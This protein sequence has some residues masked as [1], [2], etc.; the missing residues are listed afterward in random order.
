[1]N[2]Y[3]LWQPQIE[4]IEGRQVINTR[5][6]IR[7]DQINALK[8]VLI[9]RISKPSS[10]QSNTQKPSD[11]TLLNILLTNDR[12][13]VKHINFREISHMF[14]SANQYLFKKYLCI[15]SNEFHSS[16]ICLEL[17]LFLDQRKLGSNDSFIVAFS[18]Y[19]KLLP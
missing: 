11:V 18:D 1:M 9:T 5:L 16:N 4:S 17:L 10:S 2:Y 6:R 13:A 7:N 12:E 14:A 19:L 3:Q 15:H 8:R